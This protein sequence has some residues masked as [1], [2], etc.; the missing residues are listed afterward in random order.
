MKHRRACGAAEV[1]VFVRNLGSV[2]L[3]D[4]M[5]RHMYGA[6]KQRTA[7]MSETDQA[8]M[9]ANEVFVPEQLCEADGVPAGTDVV[10]LSELVRTI[11]NH[12]FTAGLASFPLDGQPRKGIG[13]DAVFAL[14]Q[15]FGLRGGLLKVGTARHGTAR[16]PWSRLALPRLRLVLASHRRTAFTASS[17][18]RS[19]VVSLHCL[20]SHRIASHL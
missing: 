17:R 18:V 6:F 1:R 4:R 11:V 20:A 8:I 5:Y 7:G 15:R 16:M 9:F 3:G 14:A 19:R 10:R 12:R 2:L 13:K